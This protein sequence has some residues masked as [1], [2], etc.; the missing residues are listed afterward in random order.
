MVART[1]IPTIFIFISASVRNPELD[2][3]PLMP[4]IASR[5]VVIISGKDL[6]KLIIPP[7]ATAP[8]P[9]YRI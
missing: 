3:L 2:E 9:I 7:A 6:I 5:N 1:A 8:A 4:F